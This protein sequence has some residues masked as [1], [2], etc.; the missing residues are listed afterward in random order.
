[1]G[2]LFGKVVKNA[3][4]AV[5]AEHPEYFDPNGSP[6]P[7]CPLVLD[8]NAYVQSVATK[9]SAGGLCAIQD[10]NAGDEMGVKRN[11]ACAESYDILT[12]Q[13][14]VRFPP[15]AYTAT[16]WPGWF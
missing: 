1:M 12:A 7:C 4:N 9:V 14:L 10:P 6:Y 13:G 3:I 8:A 2:Q 16:C 5:I 11:N 15:G